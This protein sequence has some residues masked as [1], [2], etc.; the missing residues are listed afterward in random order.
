MVNTLGR[1]GIKK[2]QK[3]KQGCKAFKWSEDSRGRL[4]TGKK[5]KLTLKQKAYL[6]DKTW[7]EHLTIKLSPSTGAQGNICC[8]PLPCGVERNASFSVFFTSRGGLEEAD[9]IH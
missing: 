7:G 1:S 6:S 2:K 9:G 3:K 5:N 4:Q 8:K